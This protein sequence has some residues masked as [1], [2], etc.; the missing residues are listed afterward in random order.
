MVNAVDNH[1]ASAAVVAGCNTVIGLARTLGFEVKT[2]PRFTADA[3]TDLD[4]KME[5]ALQALEDRD[6][7][8]VHI[9][10]PDLFAHDHQPAMKK[11]FLERVDAA[12]LKLEEAGVIIALA[13]DHSTDSN[14]GAHTADPVPALLYDPYQ[15]R[16][17]L[18]PSVNF[19]EAA[20]AAGNMPRQSSHQLLMRLL[21]RM[22][23][24]LTR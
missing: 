9:K 16:T 14:S 4:A 17:T 6:L 8:Y 22:E 3:D 23:I 5:T 1:G 13:A 18:R 19:G 12:M 21:A 2:D 11:A 7:A 20:C 24:P 10:A 15:E